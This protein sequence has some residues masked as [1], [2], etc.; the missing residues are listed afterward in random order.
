MFILR[1]SK[2]EGLN[3]DL[4]LTGGHSILVNELTREQ[5][6]KTRELMSKIFVTDDK[7]R[8]MVCFDPKSDCVPEKRKYTLYSICLEN[9][10]YDGNYGIYAN[11]L[12]VETIS[13]KYLREFTKIEL[14]M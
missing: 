14:F 11:G 12:L 13:E 3:E 2:Y 5:L 7:L 10:F 9:D 1:K 4:Y 6:Q 8:L